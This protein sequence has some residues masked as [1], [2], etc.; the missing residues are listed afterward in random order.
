[1]QSH[2]LDWNSFLESHKHC[3]ASVLSIFF[4]LLIIIYLSIFS[5]VSTLPSAAPPGLSL[6]HSTPSIMG[7]QQ[8]QQRA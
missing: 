3:L 8:H 5:C 6:S 7:I 4:S 1:M 2:P